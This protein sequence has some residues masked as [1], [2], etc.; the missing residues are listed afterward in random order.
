MSEWYRG[1]DAGDLKRSELNE[2][3][4][5][6]TCLNA[7]E[8][9]IWTSDQKIVMDDRINQKLVM[10]EELVQNSLIRMNRGW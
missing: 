1:E 5:Y 2:L 6:L 4:E 10:D 8:E 7:F 9:K 3:V